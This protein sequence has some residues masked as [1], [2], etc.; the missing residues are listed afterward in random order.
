MQP[1]GGA[2]AA[3]RPP[4]ALPAPT[5][6]EAGT[7]SQESIGTRLIRG[8]TITA[9]VVLVGF[10]VIATRTSHDVP[11]RE[12]VA[13]SV[14]SV[15]LPLVFGVCLAPLDRGCSGVRGGSS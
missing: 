4:A 12:A 9:V 5:A 1:R 14:F 2:D 13:W 10:D 3:V 6:P 8:L 15:A 11:M 7:G